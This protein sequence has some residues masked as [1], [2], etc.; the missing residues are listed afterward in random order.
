M[1][2]EGS[3]TTPEMIEKTTKALEQSYNLTNEKFSRRFAGTRWHF[4][5]SYRAVMDRGTAKV[6]K[7]P[8]TY[9]GTEHG[10]PVFWTQQMLSDKRRD[11][12]PHTFSAQCLLDPKADALQGFKR[13]WLRYYTKISTHGMNTYILV[14]AA[15]T[16]KKGSDY[17]AM[18]V[19]GL[20]T[21]GNYYALDIIR[22][23]MNLTERTARLFELHRKYRANSH[24]QQ[25]RYETYGLQADI[26]HIKS[27]Q[28]LLN[29]RFDI[30]EVGGNTPKRDR[31][32]RLIPMYE[33][34]KF[35]LPQTLHKTDY[36]KVPR[37]LV[38]SFVEEEY[39]AFPVGLHDDMLDSQ[40]RI[41]EPD[42]RLVW[43]ESQPV[44][45]DHRSFNEM[46]EMAWM[47]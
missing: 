14:D 18:W 42:L 16:K 46:G 21:D 34:G 43:P 7:H 4:N 22:D 47:G 9:D 23:R 6:R 33:Q 5:D 26:E 8:C 13:D 44:K 45:R 37:D 15:N 39:C 2:V 25:T 32:G 29:Y 28:E 19:I 35:Y 1:V 31:I 11:M 20:N 17:T 40:A 38:Y 3:V 24:L 27:Q 36:Q 41:A 12:G 30:T 10:T